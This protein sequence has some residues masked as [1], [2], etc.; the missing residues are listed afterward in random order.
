MQLRSIIFIF[1]A[2]VSVVPIYVCLTDVSKKG[3]TSSRRFAPA[4]PA[5]KSGHDVLTREKDVQL[6]PKWSSTP[7]VSPR[8]SPLS[9]YTGSCA[10][11]ALWDFLFWMI[12]KFNMSATAMVSDRFFSLQPWSGRKDILNFFIRT[13]FYSLGHGNLFHFLGTNCEK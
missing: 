10:V 2:T 4:G 12:S 7:R 3:Y 11:I 8:M 9:Y 6:N 5:N 13:V 1:I